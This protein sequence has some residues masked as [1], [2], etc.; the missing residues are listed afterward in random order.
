MRPFRRRLSGST[1][2]LLSDSKLLDDGAVTRDVFGLQIVQ[3]AAPLAHHF[4]ES[5][6]G[7]MVLR[8]NLEMTRQVVDLFAQEGN[9]NLGRTRVGGMSLIG[10]YN[11]ILMFPSERQMILLTD[12]EGEVE[13]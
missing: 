5:P 3:E 9:L 8:M 13:K 6:A 10:S 2:Q 4:Q 1:T 12:P 11:L 7:M